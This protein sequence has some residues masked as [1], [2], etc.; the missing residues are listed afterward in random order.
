M[1][2]DKTAKIMLMNKHQRK[3]K[4]AQDS[5]KKFTPATDKLD[6]QRYIKYNGKDV[7]TYD[8]K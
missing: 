5:C 1:F 7:G 3:N 6:L 8:T 2:N 4:K